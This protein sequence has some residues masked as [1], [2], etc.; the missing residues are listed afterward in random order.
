M[1]KFVLGISA[2]FLL[3]AIILQP[4]MS[5]SGCSGT[6]C[7]GLDVYDE[8][9]DGSVTT[10][11][12]AWSTNGEVY[13]YLRK[14]TTCNSLWARADKSSSYQGNYM[15]SE[16]FECINDVCSG[17]PPSNPASFYYYYPWSGNRQTASPGQS[18]SWFSDMVSGTKNSCA[19]G[20]VYTSSPSDYITNSNVYKAWAC[21]K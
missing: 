8:S 21:G 1:N 2:F 10:V 5:V 18:S 4:Q 19:R 17:S 3:A 13:T 20:W 16:A 7:R 11:N 15:L 14:S 6:T 12:Y 9:C